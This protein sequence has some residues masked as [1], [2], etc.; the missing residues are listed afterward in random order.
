MIGSWKLAPALAHD[1]S[2]EYFAGL[3]PAR[4]PRRILSEI[5]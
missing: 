3:T 4:S 1:V 5:F 2:V